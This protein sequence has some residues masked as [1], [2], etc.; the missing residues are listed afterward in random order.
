MGVSLQ[1]KIVKTRK[2]H[3]CTGCNKLFLAKRKLRYQSGVCEGDFY[4]G[5]MCE[6]CCSEMDRND[7]SDGF[8]EG[9]LREGRRERVNDWQHGRDRKIRL[10]EA[11]R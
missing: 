2:P 9:D 10:M 3:Y 1:D 11:G 6:P 7:Y 4:S 5:Y 8:S